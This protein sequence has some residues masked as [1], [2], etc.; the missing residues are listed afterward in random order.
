MRISALLSLQSWPSTI[1]VTIIIV[2][3]VAYTCVYIYIHT[4][5][6]TISI[7]VIATIVYYGFT[8]WY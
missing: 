2:Y 6:H 1:I 7:V 8:K 5:T 3:Q 4:D